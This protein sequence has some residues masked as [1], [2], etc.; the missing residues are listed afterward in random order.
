MPDSLTGR[1]RCWEIEMNGWLIVLMQ[2]FSF[3]ALICF[4]MTIWPLM[5]ACKPKSYSREQSKITIYLDA[6]SD[7]QNTGLF[8][9]GGHILGF[10]C[11]GS[12]AVASKNESRRWPD[13]G[14]EGHGKH[15]GEKIHRRGDSKK[16]LP[17]VPFGTLLGRVGEIVFPVSERKEVVV[18]SDGLLYLVINDYP[19]YRHDN[20]G[21]LSITITVQEKHR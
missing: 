13:T 10:E 21:G 12:W 15:P 11:Q 1:K 5:L 2:R 8:V 18:P 16:E 3:C 9:Q 6:R 7:W 20:R 4:F 19:F 14:P 17:G